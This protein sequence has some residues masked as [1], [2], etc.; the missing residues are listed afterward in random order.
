MT[1]FYLFGIRIYFVLIAIASVF[2]EK[3]RF[4]IK[5]R[6]GI[7]RKLKQEINSESKIAWFHCASL[8]EFEQGRPVIESFKEK[9][10]KYK[11][12]LTF[13]SP[14]GYEIRKRYE[15]ADYIFYLPLDTPKN[16]KRF[17]NIVNPSIVFF[18]KYEFWFYFIKEIGKREIPLYLISGIFRKEQRFFKK[19]GRKSEE[20]LRN[21]KHFFVQNDESK[22]L[23]AGINLNNVSVTG[24]TRFDRVYSI[25]EN[26]KKLPLIEK[27]KDK[28]LVLVAGS[29]WKPDEEILL[30]YFNESNNKLKLIIAPHEIH[31][32]NIVRITKLIL[33][34]LKTLK[35]S[36][37][38]SEN[39]STAQVLII[40]SIGMLSSLYNY[41]D[42]A[43]IG[44]GFGKG[45]HNTLE[46][47]TFGVPLLFGPNYK[48]FQEAVDLINLGGACSV[49]GH[50]ALKDKIE[51][52]TD[53][54]ENAVF[55]GKTAADYVNNNRG[56][57]LKILNFID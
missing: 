28:S 40:D 5:G 16:A 19:Y 34:N 3:A 49:S 22:R 44:G 9:Y 20:L 57:T 8:G 43:Y 27:F 7:F 21:F 10:V 51:H 55:I 31:H 12:L 46:A 1:I 11:I 23:L 56:A 37:A 24:D 6:K 17:L 30:R 39:I 42:I 33:P 47:A 26:S 52:L 2:N 38:N 4:W 50:E 29:T 13:Y 45:I 18:V 41:G 32:E 54:L 48:K 53:N 15:N 35:Y 14:S 36:D 25:A